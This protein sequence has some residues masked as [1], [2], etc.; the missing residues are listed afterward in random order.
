MDICSLLLSVYLLS[1][2]C[3]LCDLLCPMGLPWNMFPS[4]SFC[5]IIFKSWPWYFCWELDYLVLGFCLTIWAWGMWPLF[6]FW[7]WFMAVVLILLICIWLMPSSPIS[8]GLI[9]DSPSIGRFCGC[10]FSSRFFMCCPYSWWLMGG[11]CS[12]SCYLGCYGCGCC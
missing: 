4:F 11:M 2:C 6:R 10:G 12:P 8:A 5:F 7:Y 1:S 9:C 3:K